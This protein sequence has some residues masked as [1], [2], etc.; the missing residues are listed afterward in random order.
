MFGMICA[1]ALLIVLAT[2]LNDPTDER[3]ITGQLVRVGERSVAI[4]SATYTRVQRD[5]RDAPRAEGAR[6]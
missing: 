5:V 1:I 4:V 3:A 6:R 2:V